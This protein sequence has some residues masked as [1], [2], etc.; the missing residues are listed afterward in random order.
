[1]EQAHTMTG[2]AE[3]LGVTRP[4]VYELKKKG[5]LV[6]DQAGAIDVD[7]TDRK[8]A[9]EIDWPLELARGPG[10]VA[11]RL[12]ELGVVRIG[13]DCAS[14]NPHNGM[15]AASSEPARESG[16]A[17]RGSTGRQ[18]DDAQSDLIRRGG[19]TAPIC[20]AAAADVVETAPAKGAE[21]GGLTLARMDREESEAAMSRL[22]LGEKLGQVTPTADVERELSALFRGIRETLLGMPDRLAPMLAAEYD[23]ARIR[24]MLNAEIRS[25]LNGI[26]DRAGAVSAGVAGPD[27]AREDA[28]LEAA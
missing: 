25:A 24:A 6:L 22:R 2:Y 5:K 17:G 19:E 20:A 26:A 18:I 12:Q 4:Y 8:L 7:A 10:K 15:S 14:E 21:L 1:M 3:H 23:E 9:A 28:C 16:S 13:S 27:R 11:R